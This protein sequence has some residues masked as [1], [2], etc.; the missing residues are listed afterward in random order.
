MALVTEVGIVAAGVF[1]VC[2][3]VVVLLGA[4]T[5]RVKRPSEEKAFRRLNSMGMQTKK[6]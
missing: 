1:V 6:R 3:V 2:S 5:K 4:M